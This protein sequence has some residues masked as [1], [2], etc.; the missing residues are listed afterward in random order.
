MTTCGLWRAR[1]QLVAVLATPDGSV[2]RRP[3]RVADSDDARWGLVEYLALTGCA[4]VTTR[5]LA[6]IDRCP[7]RAAR[8]GL[9]VLLVDDAV[10]SAILQAAAIR[11]AA[12]AA[13]VLARFPVVPVL[14]AQLRRLAPEHRGTQLPLL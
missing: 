2:A 10:V 6:R 8:R 1:R 5:S 3:I 13:A 7:A 4:I 12:R 9:E 14:R 11:D